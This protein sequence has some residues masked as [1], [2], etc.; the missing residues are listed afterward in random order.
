MSTSSG[1][2]WR[3]A[4]SYGFLITTLTMMNF[5]FIA[6]QTSEEVEVGEECE[7]LTNR[8]GYMFIRC[9]SEIKN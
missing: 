7:N 9:G 5:K 2:K 1:C 4:A 3:E 8:G 6:L